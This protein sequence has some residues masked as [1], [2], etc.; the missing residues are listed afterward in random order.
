MLELPKRMLGELV[1]LLVAVNVAYLLLSVLHGLQWETR[2]AVVSLMLLGSSLALT[3][4][5]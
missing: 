3:R 1:V 2:V 5:R 4:L